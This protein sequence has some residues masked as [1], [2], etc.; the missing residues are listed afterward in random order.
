MSSRLDQL[1]ARAAI[2]LR[3]TGP[4]GL[5]RRAVRDVLGRGGD[6]LFEAEEA[7][8]SW[9]SLTQFSP[10]DRAL[11]HET[12]RLRGA[13]RGTRAYVMGPDAELDQEDIRS[14]RGECVIADA[15]QIA[16]RPQSY[17][18]PTHLTLLESTLPSTAT[19][20][21]HVLGRIGAVASGAELYLPLSLDIDEARNRW[22]SGAK[23]RAVAMSARPVPRRWTDVDPAGLPLL[24]DPTQFALAIAIHLGCSPIA[25]VGVSCSW[26]STADP[27]PPADVPLSRAVRPHDLGDRGVTPYAEASRRSNR[28]WHGYAQLKEIAVRRGILVQTASRESFLDVYPRV[29]WSAVRP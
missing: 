8:R 6:R 10:N 17:P 11:A 18:R 24:T 26:L 28:I 2:T 25:L 3:E 20:R 16:A 13:L 19:E 7:L 4:V 12:V 15:A 23:V 21:T 27:V 14:L 1:L 9:E 5:V 29:D 22:A